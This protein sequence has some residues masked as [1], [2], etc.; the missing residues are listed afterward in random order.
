MSNALKLLSKS[1]L[2]LIAGI[3]LGF[4]VY[5]TKQAMGPKLSVI[6]GSKPYEPIK[7]GNSLDKPMRPDVGPV[8][9]AIVA[10]E[11]PVLVLNPDNTLVFNEIVTDESVAKFL[12]KAQEMSNNLSADKEI[13]MVLYTP[14]GSVAAGMQLNDNLKAFPQ[15]I[16]TL[17]IFA[18]SMGFQ[19]VQNLD[20]RMI[21][22][23]GTL[24]SHRASGGMEGEIGGDFDVRLNAVKRQIEYMDTIASRRMKISLAD[25][26]KLIADEYWVH[27]FESVDDR[28][29]D[30]LVLARCGKDFIGTESREF[31]F[32][33]IPIQVL[34][35]KCPLITG[36]IEV[37]I[38]RDA[39]PGEEK[40]FQENGE[41]ALEF[42]KYLYSNPK[43]FYKQYIKTEKFVNIVGTVKTH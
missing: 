33:G 36:P 10:P 11:L 30:K 32:F 9:P 37:K 38:S 7:V 40:L 22:P 24:M 26:H 29:A 41:K 39:L 19:I 27:G 1:L 18:A 4:G 35:S 14:G 2:L 28:A 20:E 8:A 17:T 13:I 34:F 21:I 6:E 5:E 42:T 31:V 16:K 12:L 25:Y 3:A 23:S 43:D 15:K